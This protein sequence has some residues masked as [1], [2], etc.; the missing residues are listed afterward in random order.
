MGVCRYGRQSPCPWKSTRPERKA[1]FL[2]NNAV[3]KADY[4]WAVAEVR[5]MGLDPEKIEHE[6]TPG[7]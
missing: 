3:T 6:K 5:R 7:G 1:E 2:L 4:H